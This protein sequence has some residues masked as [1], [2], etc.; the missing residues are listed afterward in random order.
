[1]CYNEKNQNTENI[2]ELADFDIEV[3]S[4]LDLMPTFV[5]NSQP[6]K[7]YYAFSLSGID[8]DKFLIEYEIISIELNGNIINN[9]DITY[10]DNNG[11][12][13]YSSDYKENNIIKLIIRNKNTDL[14]YQ[15]E[16]QVS[17]K[18]VF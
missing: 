9:T 18:K 3:T 15:K 10:D 11:F 13:L 12:R 17:T 5:E 1:M 6:K 2:Q 7:A 4:Y 14:K 16:L 8:K